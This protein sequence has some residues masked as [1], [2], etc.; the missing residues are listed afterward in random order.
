MSERERALLGALL[1]DNSQ[2]HRVEVR[3]SD[4][5][6]VA[7]GQIFDA[8]RRMVGAGAVADA[9]TVAEALE[10]ETGRKEWLSMTGGMVLDCLS[11]ANAS[12][13]AK[14]IRESAVTRQAAAIGQDLCD[15]GSIAEAIQKLMALTSTDKNHACHVVDAL[16]GAIDELDKIQDGQPS[17]IMTGIRDL[18]ESLGGLHKQDLVIVAARP[19]MGKT[20]WMLNVACAGRG[21]MGIISGEQGRVQ[22]GMRMIAIDGSVNLHHMRT[23]KLG[24]DE[25][26]RVSKAI[27]ACKEK[28]IWIY[29]K[30]GPTLEE[31]ISQARQW[32]FNQRIELL[33]IDYLQ[34][35]RGGDGKDFR[36]QIGDIA[37][38]L[39]NLARELDIPIVALAQVKREVESRPMGEDGMGRMPYMGDIAESAIIEHE[40]D[41]V[42]TLYRPEVYEQAPQLKGVAY[43]NICKNRHGPDGFKRIHWRGEHV[44]FSDSARVEYSAQGWAS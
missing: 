11:P 14:L 8:V 17:G 29:D 20:A 13:Y 38:Q 42:I 18:D 3:S 35:I 28:P 19:A 25:W 41:Q 7:Y 33:M 22:I 16:N 32:R 6:V 44:K 27:N 5:S 15:G 10:R 2:L 39:K 30:P 24:D 23:A 31:I 43:V 21:P 9:L 34:K 36:L 12:S 37:V 4:F 26:S 1:A 40:A